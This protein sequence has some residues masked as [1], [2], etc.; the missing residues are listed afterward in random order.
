MTPD[1]HLRK[2]ADVSN[3]HHLHSE[4]PEEVNDL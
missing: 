4:V 3:S 2:R 1:I